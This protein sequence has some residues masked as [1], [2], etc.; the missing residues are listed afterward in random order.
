M[1]DFWIALLMI[2]C[3]VFFTVHCSV[4][5]RRELRSGRALGGKFGNYDRASAPVSFWLVTAGNLVAAAM[6]AFFIFVG[7]IGLLVYF[8]VLK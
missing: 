8:E 7:S 2:V 4:A 3:G 6:G 5:A 1:R